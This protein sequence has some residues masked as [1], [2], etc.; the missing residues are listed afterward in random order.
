MPSY[1]TALG[2]SVDMSAL[3]AKNENVRA[4]GNMNV[5]ARGDIIDQANRVVQRA[6]ERAAN[7]YTKSVNANLPPPTKTM[8]QPIQEDITPV[9]PQE[10]LTEEEKQFE[11]EDE[12]ITKQIN[13]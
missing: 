8:G 12:E 7:Q 13:K 3:K 2:K 1:K 10:E 5:N 4:V 6:T 11:K 9:I